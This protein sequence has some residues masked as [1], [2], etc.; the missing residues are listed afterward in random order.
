MAA[1]SGEINYTQ[2]LAANIERSAYLKEEACKAAFS[3]FDVDGDGEI[4]RLDHEV[5]FA[6][7]PDKQEELIKED[8]EECGDSA[9]AIVGVERAEIE[10]IMVE[11]DKN[12]SGSITFDEFVAMMAN[13]NAFSHL[14]A[15]GVGS[16]TAAA[17]AGK[18]SGLAKKRR[19]SFMQG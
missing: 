16:A 3:L 17:E 12:G 9:C 13:K 7:G 10:R 1:D 19:D 14:K 11:S 5:L 4:S 6:C 8:D 2:F 18:V 15:G